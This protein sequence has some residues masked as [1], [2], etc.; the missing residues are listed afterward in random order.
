MATTAVSYALSDCGRRRETNEDRYFADESLGLFIVCDGMGGHAAGEVAAELATA[1]AASF[2]RDHRSELAGCDNSQAGLQR[3]Q[4]IAEQAVEEACRRVYHAACNQAKVAGMGTTMT[5]VL[6]RTGKAVMAHVGDSRLYLVRDRQV[7]LLSSDHTLAYDLLHAGA[8][9]QEELATSRFRNVL[10]RCVGQQ[11]FTEVELLV[12][13]ILPGD[14]LLLCTDGLSNYL[15]KADSPAAFLDGDNS[16]E[17]P[18]RLVHYANECGGSDN[19]TLVLIEIVSTDTGLTS[20]EL[21]LRLNALRRS[22]LCPTTSTSR[23]LRVLN[24]ACAI[25]CGQDQS[26]FT[27]G[28]PCDGLYIVLSGRLTA[29]DDSV[30]GRDLVPGD[31]IGESSLVRK[32]S[33]TV[34]L[35]ADEPSRLLFIPRRAFVRLVK[36][37]PKLG[38]EL[39]RNLAKYLSQQM[40]EPLTES[41]RNDTLPLQ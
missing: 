18:Q 12:F 15:E 6:V 17:I 8:I 37:L 3:V 14:R 31:C 21:Q 10:T 36:K 20:E 7:H 24:I 33:F 22:F 5:L 11:E 30:L 38:N 34:S 32:G 23:K 16:S 13:D 4:D 40:E 39:L 41:R 1:T 26:L 35:K 19:I 9:S 28:Q 29:E 2:V 25:E 27:C